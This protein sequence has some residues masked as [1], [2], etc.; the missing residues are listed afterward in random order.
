MSNFK[1]L[2]NGASLAQASLRS[3]ATSMLLTRS[4][5][6]SHVRGGIGVRT[7]ACFIG[8][9]V[10]LEP[11]L[12]RGLFELTLGP[13]N[14]CSVAAHMAYAVC[15][16]GNGGSIGED[17][18][19]LTV[20][21]WRGT[22]TF[23]KLNRF[24]ACRDLTK[25]KNLPLPLLLPLLLRHAPLVPADVLWVSMSHKRCTISTQLKPEYI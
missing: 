22:L 15:A 25:Q 24:A 23:H 2:R 19:G 18:L 4:T 3:W 13:H 16:T 21:L 12:W 9:S 6:P 11:C 5:F 8:F 20:Q 10:Y 17:S 7:L 1:I 14:L